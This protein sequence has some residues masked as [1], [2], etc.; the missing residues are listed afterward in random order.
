MEI[1]STSSIN[2]ERATQSL[3]RGVCIFPPSDFVKVEIG[4]GLKTR[5]LPIRSSELGIV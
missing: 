5:G 1:G 3:L 4:K 2:N